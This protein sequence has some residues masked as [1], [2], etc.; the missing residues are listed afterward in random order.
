MQVFFL[1]FLRR[2]QTGSEWNVKKCPA[3]GTAKPPVPA[4]A[5]LQGNRR[6]RQVCVCTC[7]AQSR[8]GKVQLDE[9]DT[10]QEVTWEESGGFSG[11]MFLL[12]L[13]NLVI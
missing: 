1:P 3:F 7:V 5:Q 13:G 4:H 10:F 12:E 9:E 2:T 8:V 6:F 11:G